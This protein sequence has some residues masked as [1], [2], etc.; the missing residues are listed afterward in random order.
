MEVGA[1]IV[2]ESHGSEKTVKAVTR[3]I[4]ESIEG[5]AGR[6]L[7][8]ALAV[9]VMLVCLLQMDE[10]QKLNLLGQ[11]GLCLLILF[12]CAM[13]VMYLLLILTTRGVEVGIPPISEV[14]ISQPM[15]PKVL[16][17]VAGVFWLV[18]F[19]FIIGLIY[20]LHE[21]FGTS[22]SWWVWLGVYLLL[23]LFDFLAYGYLLLFVTAFTR[24]RVIINGLWQHRFGV[25][26]VIAVL[27]ILAP[28]FLPIHRV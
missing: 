26:Q 14:A 21:S 24:N 10:I 5:I 4:L 6:V 19:L 11:V 20:I 18:H 23:S 25:S 27:S 7:G 13:E 17:P 3:R 1:A 22:A 8:A 16:R 15:L 2:D 28:F 12:V 9:C